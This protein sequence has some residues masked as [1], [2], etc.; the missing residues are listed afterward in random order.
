MSR[1]IASIAVVGGGG[2]GGDANVMTAVL[3]ANGAA[4]RC[5]MR[6]RPSVRPSIH[7]REIKNGRRVAANN[8]RRENRV[9]SSRNRFFYELPYLWLDRSEKRR[10]ARNGGSVIEDYYYKGL[11]SASVT[12][13][14]ADVRAFRLG[15]PRVTQPLVVDKAAR[16]DA[17]VA[18]CDVGRVHS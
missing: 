9:P 6:V 18:R 8:G 17:F 5:N 4:M 10:S 13:T 3:D 12:H 7:P 15:F 11:S 2:G 16:R 1:A 14:L